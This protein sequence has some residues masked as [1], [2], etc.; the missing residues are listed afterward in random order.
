MEE[1]LYKELIND[2]PE[3]ELIPHPDGYLIERQ[4]S[5]IR[6]NTLISKREYKPSD[7]K[8]KKT[9]KMMDNI[10]K[11]FANGKSVSATAEILGIKPSTIYSW[12]RSDEKFNQACLE[13]I[14]I[15]TDNQEV[16]L[17]ERIFRGTKKEVYN[18]AGEL[19]RTEYQQNDQ[20]LL[21]SLA[22][23]RPEKWKQ[24]ES[25]NVNIV[26]NNSNALS[27]VNLDFDLSVQELSKLGHMELAVQYM[28]MLDNE[29][30]G[31]EQ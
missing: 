7:R 16:E 31:N 5:S 8:V 12:R 26:N 3:V 25:G 23:R 17:Q 22:A 13:A 20:L 27:N 30:K 21:R 6:S 24:S 11:C 18:G 10:I 4:I 15:E 28:N 1:D 9:Q 19:E 2:E 29:R 14:D